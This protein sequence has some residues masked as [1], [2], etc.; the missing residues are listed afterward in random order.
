MQAPGASNKRKQPPLLLL[1]NLQCLVYVKTGT[2][3]SP[4][5]VLATQKMA[6][7]KFYRCDGKSSL[8]PSCIDARD[9]RAMCA[10]RDRVL[11]T[12]MFSEVR[13]LV[14]CYR[15][16]A[17][18]VELFAC[19]LQCVPSCSRHLCQVNQRQLY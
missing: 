14:I 5:C 19:S 10:N 9:A 7:Q 6:C 17:M 2:Y 4:D 18:T 15:H 13:C 1:C 11:A 12:R 3:K 8:S 16:K